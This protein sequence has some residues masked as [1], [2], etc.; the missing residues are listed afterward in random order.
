MS[1]CKWSLRATQA[2]RSENDF[3]HFSFACGQAFA[4]VGSERLWRVVQRCKGECGQDCLAVPF[5]NRTAV[6]VCFS[7]VLAGWLEVVSLL[8]S[9][10]RACSVELVGARPFQ[11]ARGAV[12]RRHSISGSSKRADARLTMP[13]RWARLK[14]QMKRTPNWKSAWVFQR[15]QHVGALCAVLHR[16]RS[17]CS[18]GGGCCVCLLKI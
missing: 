3:G 17:Q 14:K 6:A 18:F 13:R 10:R 16:G 15:V 7:T 12:F 4:F 9:G 2:K 5:R 1:T 11:S 8:G